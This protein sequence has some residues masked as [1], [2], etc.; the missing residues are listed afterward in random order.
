MLLSGLDSG[1][2][3]LAPQQLLVPASGALR[4]YPP[5]L[6][7]PYP[8]PATHKLLPVNHQYAFSGPLAGRRLE[9]G[10]DDGGLF[11]GAG[12]RGGGGGLRPWA[13]DAG[14]GA[15]PDGAVRFDLPSGGHRLADP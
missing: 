11:P 9:H 6:A 3:A 13:M 14:G 8:P 4:A 10:G 5:S 2:P 1:R 7:F 15:G 12:R